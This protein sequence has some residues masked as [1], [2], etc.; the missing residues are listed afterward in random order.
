MLGRIV[1]QLR[2]AGPRKVAIVIVA[3]IVAVVLAYGD[4]SSNDAASGR[5]LP[6][7]MMVKHIAAVLP[8]SRH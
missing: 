5:T 2:R 7:S 4:N 8:A 6:K 1:E 3:L